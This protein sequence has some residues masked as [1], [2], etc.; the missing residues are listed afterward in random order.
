[1]NF[2]ADAVGDDDDDDYSAFILIHQRPATMN[3]NI[4]DKCSIHNNNK[5]QNLGNSFCCFYLTHNQ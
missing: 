3:M 5:R 1:M 2:I 4:Y